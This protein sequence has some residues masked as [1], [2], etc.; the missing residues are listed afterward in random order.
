M[1]LLDNIFKSK[2]R[3][4]KQC[5]IKNLLL[6]AASNDDIAP[7]ELDFLIKVANRI[8]ISREDFAQ[9][10]RS[11]GDIDFYPPESDFE[12]IDQ[13]DDLV[14]MMLVDGDIDNEEVIT[15][16]KFAIM[17]GF[18]P[19]IIDLILGHILDAAIKNMRRELVIDRLSSLIK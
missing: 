17:L 4:K 2:E 14:R 18:K 6:V 13:L 12:R 11:P 3:R 15:C 10:L 5:H 7:N 8:G 19:E 9:V 1:G 16:Q